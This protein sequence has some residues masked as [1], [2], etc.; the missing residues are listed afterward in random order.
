MSALC[1]TAETFLVHM[2]Q[3]LR[4]IVHQMLNSEIKVVTNL[5]RIGR[6]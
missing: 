3:R 6:R 5:L 4:T 1:F 2:N